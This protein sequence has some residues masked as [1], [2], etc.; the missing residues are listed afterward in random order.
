MS[1]LLCPICESAFEADLSVTLPFCSDRCR[2]IDL[3]R[4]FKEDYS[5]PNEAEP[6]G[7]DD[8]NCG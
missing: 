8:P 2:Q 5:L 6:E 7:L 3:G 1:N 4:W